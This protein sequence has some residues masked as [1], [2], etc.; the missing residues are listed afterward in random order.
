MRRGRDPSAKRR[1]CS[2]TPSRP[3]L[4][5]QLGTRNLENR[6]SLQG[7]EAVQYLQLIRPDMRLTGSHPLCIPE[8]ALTVKFPFPQIVQKTYFRCRPYRVRAV[9]QAAPKEESA[10]ESSINLGYNEREIMALVVNCRGQRPRLREMEP[11]SDKYPDHAA[12]C[13]PDPINKVKAL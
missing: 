7:S 1:N 12:S 5:R 4:S 9:C 13:R 10:N 3:S 8:T 2:K 6:V 11:I